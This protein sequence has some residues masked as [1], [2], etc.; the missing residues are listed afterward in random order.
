MLLI[1]LEIGL[2]YS[3]Y[4]V[5]LVLLV[6]INSHSC[7]LCI[8]SMGQPR[9]RLVLRFLFLTLLSV[10]FFAV[11]SGLGLYII[12]EIRLIP[13]FLILIG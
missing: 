2:G 8:Y 3:Q 12:F 9:P 4:S 13:I 11:R 7:F 5:L 6:L 10:G 1:S